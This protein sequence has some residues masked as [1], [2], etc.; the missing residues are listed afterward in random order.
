MTAAALRQPEAGAPPARAWRAAAESAA[1]TLALPAVGWAVDPHDPFAI[2]RAFSWALV[3]PLLV[4]LRYGSGFGAASAVS[5]G[6]LAFVGG[7]A[8]VAAGGA[9]SAEAML[10]LLAVP[11]VVGQASAAWRREREALEGGLRDATRRLGALSRAHALLE[12][13]H[14]RLRQEHAG[15]ADVRDALAAALRAPGDGGGATDATLLELCARHC[16]VEVASLHDVIE[17]R[18]VVVVPRAVLGRP[19]PVDPDD[20]L[21][22]RAIE[23]GRLAHLPA[24]AISADA[25]PASQLLACVPALDAEGAVRSIIC[26]HA[27][28]F[29]EFRG[30]NLRALAALGGQAATSLAPPTSGD[31]FERDLDRQVERAARDAAQGEGPKVIAALAVQQGS[32]VLGVLDAVLAD[33]LGEGERPFVC[34]RATGDCVVYVLFAR[35]GTADA[36]AFRERVEQAVRRETGLSLEAAGGRF[37][38]DV[39]SPSDTGHAVARRFAKTMGFEEELREIS[40]AG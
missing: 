12:L 38:V 35:T 27:M 5:V 26:V 13:S 30:G 4:A 28:P 39:V 6:V 31:A 33:S 7:R 24:D 23:T 29:M 34:R 16:S 20:P 10:G 37:G 9:L 17:G 21:V 11:V 22:A 3:A 14:Q 2:H 40:A 8:G 18:R 1:L 25:A 19:E 32:A 36:Q 15:A